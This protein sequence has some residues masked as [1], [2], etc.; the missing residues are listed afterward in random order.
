MAIVAQ[1]CFKEEDKVVC[2][3]A[4]L[5]DLELTDL[6]EIPMNL[7]SEGMQGVFSGQE[8]NLTVYPDPRFNRVRSLK[9]NALDIV[10]SGPSLCT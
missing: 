7:Y 6:Y 10:N 5:S 2:K 3:T 1:E 8:G 9:Y 4:A